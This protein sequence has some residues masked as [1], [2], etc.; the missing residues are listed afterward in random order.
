M[1]PTSFLGTTYSTARSGR[2]GP[3]SYNGYDYVVGLQ[4]SPTQI[5]VFKR[6][7]T[8]TSGSFTA[9][10]TANAPSYNVQN[11]NYRVMD[12]QQFGDAIYVAYLD[13][14]AVTNG[15]RVAKFDM[16]TDLW[17][18]ITAASG[19]TVQLSTIGP[20]VVFLNVRA[21]GNYVLLFQGSTQSVMGSGYRR[22]KYHRYASGSWVGTTQA[23]DGT[24]TTANHA[25]L[26]ASAVDA[27]G[28]V[29]GFY[30]IGPNNVYRTLNASNVLSTETI[31]GSATV[32]LSTATNYTMGHAAVIDDTTDQVI[33]PTIAFG[34]DL[35]LQYANVADAP[36]FSDNLITSTNDPVETTFSA[37]VAVDGTT[38]YVFW[39]NAAG[40]V[41]YRDSGTTSSGFGTD[42]SF[43]TDI[44]LDGLSIG[45]VPNG[46]G[47]I[48]STSSAFSYE[49]YA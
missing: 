26:K 37:S 41:I 40:T 18:T 21:D 47:V 49:R 2:H 16:T 9:L 45:K 42:V 30:N 22:V 11:I 39:I 7:S 15:F 5:R 29:Y 36:L 25:D 23:F 46:I 27:T 14:T 6:I 4:A 43:L 48:Y 32:P 17:S 8:A 24:G 20:T 1:T 3:F 38:V 19:D 44:T 33:V 31:F 10:D 34:G 12:A 28:R 13:S 35:S